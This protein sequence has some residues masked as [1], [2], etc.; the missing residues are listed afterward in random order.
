MDRPWCYDTL[1]P[2]VR[3][4]WEAHDKTCASMG[5]FWLG[6]CGGV[7]CVSDID[8]CASC[9]ATFYNEGLASKCPDYPCDCDDSFVYLCECCRRVYA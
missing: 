8:T 2:T 7:T 4:D 6:R 1:F 5:Y 9:Q 3:E